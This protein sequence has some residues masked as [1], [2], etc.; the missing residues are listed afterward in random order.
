M[1][2]MLGIVVGPAGPHAMET[3]FDNSCSSSTVLAQQQSLGSVGCCQYTPLPRLA[4]VRTSLDSST[5]SVTLCQHV[6]QRDGDLHGVGFDLW[7][8]DTSHVNQCVIIEF[9]CSA[10]ALDQQLCND[11]AGYVHACSV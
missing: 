5:G 11:A 9:T 1:Q 3:R 7:H 6:K 4:V 2:K 8:A 10:D